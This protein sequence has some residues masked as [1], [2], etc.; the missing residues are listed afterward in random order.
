MENDVMAWWPT[1]EKR[2]IRRVETR[3]DKTCITQLEQIILL[4]HDM[5]SL[6]SLG[7]SASS[8]KLARRNKCSGKKCLLMSLLDS[9]KI[10]KGVPALLRN[11][12]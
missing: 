12:S 6:S 9:G 2:A 11:S 4:A 10:W 5:R 8:F 1:Q 3:N 7:N